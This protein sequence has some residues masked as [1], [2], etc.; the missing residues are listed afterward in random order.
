MHMFPRFAHTSVRSVPCSV[1]AF[2][3]YGFAVAV[4]NY[5]RRSQKLLLLRVPASAG[6]SLDRHSR[7]FCHATL[8]LSLFPTVAPALHFSSRSRTERKKGAHSHRTTFT[9]SRVSVVRRPETPTNQLKLTKPNETTTK[10][11]LNFSWRSRC[12]Y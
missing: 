7:A 12:R 6:S 11:K 2:T 3:G 5:F 8:S 4:Y 9:V 10:L 1:C